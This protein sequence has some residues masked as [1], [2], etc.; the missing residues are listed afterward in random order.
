MVAVLEASSRIL[1]L[2]QT[3]PHGEGR[4]QIHLL[5]KGYYPW[6]VYGIVISPA[7]EYVVFRASDMPLIKA[8]PKGTSFGAYPKGTSFGAWLAEK[9]RSLVESRNAEQG[10][11]W[12]PE[13]DI[14][15]CRVN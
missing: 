9:G 5:D 7:A 12:S 15:I 8:C 11:V 6:L 13:D 4:G 1:F 10:H 2:A 14:F 3:L